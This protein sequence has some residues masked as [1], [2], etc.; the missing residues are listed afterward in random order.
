MSKE[1]YD[2]LS[3][4]ALKGA[5]R[6]RFRPAVM[7]GS[8]D[9]RGAFH[10]FNEILGNSLDEAR[11]GYGKRVNAKLYADGSM[12]IEDFG[13][14]VPMDWNANENCYNWQLVFDELY[15]G[16]KYD[17]SE[18]KFSLGLN[19]L[20]A[21]AVQYTSDFMEVVVHRDGKEYAMSFKKGKADGEMSVKNAPDAPTGTY[22]RW[23]PDDEVF[24]STNITFKMIYDY[25]ESQAHLNEVA[26]AIEDE[27][28]PANNCEIEGKGLEYYLN[29][30][31]GKY[32]TG[33]Y[34][35]ADDEERFRSVS[36]RDSHDKAYTCKLDLVLAVTEEHAPEYL[37]FHNTANVH[38]GAHYYGIQNALSNF[39]KRVG[40]DR[41]VILQPSDYQGYFSIAV[42]TFS[43]ITSF[44]NQTKDS[45]GNDFVQ[46][47][48]YYA[49]YEKL[50]LLYAKQDPHIMAVCD[51]AETMAYARKAAKEA[52]LLARKAKKVTQT[53]RQTPEKFKDCEET[54]PK[55]RE[56]YI[57]EGDSA[58]GSCKDA[59][60]AQFQALIPV[61][62]KSLNCLKAS[63]TAILENTEVQD[64]ISVLG[65]GVEVGES[66]DTFNINKLQFDK[67]I[68]CTDG[69]VDGFQIRTLL[70]TML[71]RL[72]PKLIE[73]GHVYIVETPL[74]EIITTQ[75]GSLFAYN[76]REK[77][78]MLAQLA[79]E[80][81]RVEKVNRSKGLGENDPEMMALT[82]MNPETRR[83]VQLKFDPK[84]PVVVDTAN[85]LFGEDPSKMRSDFIKS[86]FGAVTSEMLDTLSALQSED[87]ANE[88]LAALAAQENEEALESMVI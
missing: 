32:I 43:N 88:E 44:A 45:V 48:V 23:K 9:I 28:N 77:D 64:I 13:R 80:G 81:V 73:L 15:A 7:L 25:C 74:F 31:V 38:G 16:G 33:I 39:F 86:M 85:M 10:T 55:K 71:F 57:L 52:E 53:K 17:D 24:T 29:M 78:E 59:R 36:G 50:S 42:S 60:N 87:E 40:S 70:L 56:L 49:L 54:D 46:N 2:N 58:L 72:V 5:D 75:R 19:G 6:V 84:D 37:L 62:G 51:S 47:L 30:K 21:T 22:I 69:D 26:I 41:G 27:A 79:K 65:V 34:T 1:S 3:I 20:G 61:R 8:D 76:V 14:G 11:A 67:I 82:T 18:Y 63:Y 83:L 12:S 68:I 4:K 66:A 35:N